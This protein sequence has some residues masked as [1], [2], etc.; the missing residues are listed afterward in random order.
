MPSRSS[1]WSTRRIYELAHRREYDVKTMC[2]APEVTRSGFY[3]WLH[4]PMSSRA[5]EDARLLRLIRASCKAGQ[6]IYGLPCVFLDLREAGET[7][8][9]S[10]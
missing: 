3:A 1:A 9:Q 5:K 4:E 6:G 8:R 10:T 2:H 7:R